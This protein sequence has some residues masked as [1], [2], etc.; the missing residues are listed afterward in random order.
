MK[1]PV[2]TS[3]IAF[4]CAMPPEPVVDFQTK[5]HR[6]DENGEP[7]YVIQLLAMGDGSADLLAVKVPGVPSSALRQGVPVK[8]HVLVAKPWTMQDRSG[9]LCGV[10]RRNRTG[11]PS[12]PWNH[13]EPLCGPPFPQVTPDRKGQSYRFSSGEVMRSVLVLRTA[14]CRLSAI[15]QSENP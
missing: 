5:Q 7:L 11:D 14:H 4:L 1:L 10:P 9:T 15:D 8:V 6:A 12:L 2:D 13:R 3:A